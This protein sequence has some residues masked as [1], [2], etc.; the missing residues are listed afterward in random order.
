MHNNDDDDDD[1]DNEDDN[2]N[3]IF[4]LPFQIYKNPYD[5]GAKKNWMVFLGFHNF[6]YV[7][8]FLFSIG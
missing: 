1:D 8:L 4:F 3:S 5:Y 7:F 6:R 2:S